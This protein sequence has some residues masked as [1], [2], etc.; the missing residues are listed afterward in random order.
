LAWWRGEFVIVKRES[1]KP[2]YSDF[3]GVVF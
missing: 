2:N 1:I 3:I